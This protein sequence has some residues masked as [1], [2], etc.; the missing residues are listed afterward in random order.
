MQLENVKI[1]PKIIPIFVMVT[2]I[3]FLPQI[4]ASDPFSFHRWL[5][6]A[7]ST[8]TVWI[9]D[10]NNTT[11]FVRL[12]GSDTQQLSSPFTWDW[13]DG[14]V[15][16]GWF[17]QEHTYIDLNRNYIMK[18]TA[19][20]G[21][22][23]EDST[24]ILV[25][26]VPSTI[27]PISTSPSI[28]VYIPNHSVNLTSRIPGYGVPSNLTFFDDSFF[29]TS[30]RSLVEYLLT[31][32]ATIQQDFVNDNLYL[33][34]NAFHQYLLRD[35][36]TGGMYSL[37][38]TNPVAFGV[39]DDG[40][41]GTIEYSSFMHEMGHNST[42][43][44]PSNY[45]FGGKI[46]GNAN[47]IYS[48]TMANIFAH[49]TAYLFLNTVDSYGIDEHLAFEIEQ[50]ATSS[51]KITRNAYDE[52][53]QS[54][55]NFFSWNDPATPEDETFTTFQTLAFRFC[56]HGEND[57]QGYRKPLKRM[58]R[59]LQSFNEDLHA[60]FDQSSNNAS[61]DTFRATLMVSALSFGFLRDLR[62]EFRTLN[63]P[64]DDDIFTA[65]YDT[66]TPVIEIVSPN[67]GESLF[68]GETEMI[69]WTSENTSS[70]IKIEYSTNGGLEWET[71]VSTN[72]DEG[73]YQWIVP[74]TPSANCLVNICDIESDDWCDQ[75]DETFVILQPCEITITSPNGGESWC[76]TDNR[77]IAWSSHGTSGRVRIEYSTN[78]G[79]DWQTIVAD[80][81]DSGSSVWTLPNAPSVDYIVRLCDSEE[82]ACCDTSDNPFKI[83]SCGP[84]EIVTDSLSDAHE[85]VPYEENL[86]AAGGVLPYFWSLISGAMPAGFTLE[87]NTGTISGRPEMTGAYFFTIEVED[88]VGTTASR[89]YCLD[90]YQYHG[91]KGDVNGDGLINIMDVLAVVNHILNIQELEENAFGWADCNGDYQIN[92][93]DALGIVNVV[94]GNGECES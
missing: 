26:F 16:D 13:D 88:G 93:M 43:N 61:A 84:L 48:E 51:I 37:W 81:L 41:Q 24:K 28:E 30:S 22:G 17:P 72:P 52:Y 56:E 64:I 71:I 66:A 35:P 33:I 80:V 78:G 20:Y 19:H 70:E 74:N 55:M 65:L 34:D 38:Y 89:E 75:S 42:L 3:T 62:T 11:G 87:N 18:V 54:G 12:N 2:S 8:L 50:S 63:F 14:T 6:E 23:S 7:P 91:M 32:F 5:F 10:I 59:L 86:T 94:L 57:G 39:G 79:S 15:N 27:D 1:N 21:D 60:S 82:T 44:T 67:G 36:T 49:G 40:F 83:S 90:V 76:A 46:D 77:T 68:V 9:T 85:T 4:T 69:T 58:M 92:I 45:I 29:E 47:A 25:R 73:L 53:I 31:I